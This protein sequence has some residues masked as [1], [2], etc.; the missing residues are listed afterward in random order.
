MFAVEVT[1]EFIEQTRATMALKSQFGLDGSP[2][3]VDQFQPP[4]PW[5]REKYKTFLE[6]LVAQSPKKQ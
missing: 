5:H 1:P 3:P 6:R 4:R 2:D